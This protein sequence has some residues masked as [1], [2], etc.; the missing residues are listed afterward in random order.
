MKLSVGEVKGLTWRVKGAK[1]YIGAVKE[2]GHLMNGMGELTRWGLEA[3]VYIKVR[4]IIVVIG[5]G[6]W[7]S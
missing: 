1:G 4:N 3:S 6:S 2:A 7:R 5:V